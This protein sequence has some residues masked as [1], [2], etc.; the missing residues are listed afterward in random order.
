M[1]VL[2]FIFPV[3][4]VL[5]WIFIGMAAGV[6]FMLGLVYVIYVKNEHG[7]NHNRR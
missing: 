5:R 2:V 3:P 6:L 7:G 4:P 1:A